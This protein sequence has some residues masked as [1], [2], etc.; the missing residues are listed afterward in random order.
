ESNL[1]ADLRD[2]A[3]A[4]PGGWNHEDWIS[5]LDHL[6]GRGHDVTDAD[7]VGL[8][9]ERERLTL[10]LERIPGMGPRRVEALVNR[11]HTLYSIS[12]ADVDE[13]AGVQGM[14]RALAE[15]VR[16]QFA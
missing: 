1:R 8:S 11:Y 2:F 16:Q 3:S 10:H 7:G 5:F 13:L 4:R 14:N 12:H 15:K 6:R 9:L